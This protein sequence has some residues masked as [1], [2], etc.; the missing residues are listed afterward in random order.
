MEKFDHNG[1]R[2]WDTQT[3]I[4]TNIRTKKLFFHS[5]LP[6][7]LTQTGI[8][9]CDSAVIQLIIDQIDLSPIICIC[10]AANFTLQT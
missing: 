9:N 2:I 4:M 1:R 8:I 10:N 5:S 7:L 3:A 6:F